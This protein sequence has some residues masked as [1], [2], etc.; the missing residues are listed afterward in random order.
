[1]LLGAALGSGKS[2]LELFE[3]QIFVREPSDFHLKFSV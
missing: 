2:S 1:M 3:N